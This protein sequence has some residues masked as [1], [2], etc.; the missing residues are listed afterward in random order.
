MSDPG[1]LDP[2]YQ[3]HCIRPDCDRAFNIY[4]VMNG[5]EA[6]APGWRQLTRVV[7]GYLCPEHAAPCAD[8]S[9]VPRWLASEDIAVIGCTCGGF[10][11]SRDGDTAGMY[12][13][14][15]I[16]HLIDVTKE[17]AHA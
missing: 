2:G 17:I 14:Q 11:Y 16:A 3:R 10:S 12:Q 15:W 4:D 7:C 8:G 9:H 5:D 1:R 13:A 6:A